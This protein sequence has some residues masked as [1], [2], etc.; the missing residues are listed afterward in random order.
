M[1]TKR[2]RRPTPARTAPRRDWTPA[3]APNAAT[4]GPESDHGDSRAPA[5]ARQRI[6]ATVSKSVELG[7]KVI[8]EYL[9]QGQHAAQR[10]NAG[11]LTAEAVATEAQ[12]LGTRVARYASDFFGAW[13]ELLEL[14][15][16]GRAAQ[17]GGRASEPSSSPSPDA[18]AAEAS[19]AAPA[20][21]PG[22]ASRAARLQ[23]DLA[24]SRPVRL[25]LDLHADRIRGALRAHALRSADPSRGQLQDVACVLDGDA[26]LLRVEVSAEQRS[27]SYEGLLVDE[28]TNRPV[29]SVRVTLEDA[30]RRAQPR[31]S[32]KARASK[33]S[34]SSK[35][36]SRRR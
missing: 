23:V 20:P 6:E 16:A 11:T 26:P 19:A 32:S 25:R 31:S 18:P 34:P 13:M 7:Y 9:Q 2:I 28:T 8:D 27:G 35:P 30:R 14:A 10:L 33:A 15:A 29:G 36:S 5:G 1:S 21:A 24:T 3:P 4:L 12:D 17:G 22:R